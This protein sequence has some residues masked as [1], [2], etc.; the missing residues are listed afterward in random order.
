MSYFG[1]AVSVELEYDSNFKGMN[2]ITLKNGEF[3]VVIGLDD[4]QSDKVMG[5]IERI[6]KEKGEVIHQQ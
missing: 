4:D 2:A 5:F 1:K 3:K 6:F